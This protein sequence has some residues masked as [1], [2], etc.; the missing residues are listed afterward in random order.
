MWLYGQE[1]GTCV[2]IGMDVGTPE[3]WQGVAGRGRRRWDGVRTGLVY[4]QLVSHPRY[5]VVPC[6]G[7]TYLALYSM[8]TGVNVK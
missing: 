4:I 1:V 8:P 7:H 6:A 2:G 5:H 3:V